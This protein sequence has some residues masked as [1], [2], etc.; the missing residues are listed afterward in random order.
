M[1]WQAAWIWHPPK[2]DMDNFYLHARKL[3]ELPEPPEEPL[4]FVTASSLYKLFVNGR[5]VGRGPNPADPSRYYFDTYEVG[6]YLQAGENV[7]AALCYN[8]G[9][10]PHGILNQNWGRG[11]FLLEIRAPGA[12]GETLLKTD[13]SW[14]VLQSPAREQDAA[15]NCT[16]YGDFKEIYDSQKEPKGWLEADFDD[17]DWHEAEVLGTP[18]VEPWTRLIPREIPFLDGERV[19]PVNAFWESASVTYSWREDNEVYNHW[20]LA[21]DCSRGDEEKPA[22]ALRTHA[23]FAPSIILDFGRD[24]TGYLRVV[25]E[26]SAGGVV[27]LLYGEDLYLTRVD[28]FTLKGGPQV[29]EPYNRRTFRYCKLLFRETPDWV[30]IGEVSL[31]MDTY[32][33]EHK[34]AFRCSDPLLNR[35]WEVG[36]YTMRMS[37]LDHFVDCPWRERTLYGGDMW[38]ENLIAHY[39]FGDPR[40]NAKCLRQMANIQHAGG[41]LPPYGPYR[42]ADGFYPS[43]SAFWALALL[44]H[45][46]FTADA[47]LLEELWPNLEKLLDWAIGEMEEG[48]HLIGRPSKSIKRQKGQEDYDPFQAWTEA[49]KDRH[50]PWDNLPFAVLLRR[51]AELARATGREEEAE[52]YA[53]AAERMGRALTEE[54][55]DPETSLCRARRSGGRP[56]QY[57]TGMLLWADLLS[58]GEASVAVRHL[59]DPE[60]VPVGAPFGGLFVTE[61]LFGS[62]AAAEALRFIRDYWGGMLARGATTYWDNFSLAWSEGVVPGRNTSLCH[63]WAAG[64]TYSLPAH[65]LGV[66]PLEPGF[67]R[68]IVAPQPGDVDWASGAVPTPHGPVEVEWTRNAEQFRLEL[69]VPPGSTAEV[70]V[71]VPGVGRSHL[72]LD[73]EQVEGGRD[74]QRRLVEVGPGEHAVLVRAKAAEL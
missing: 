9:P 2:E 39:A 14:R 49:D 64:P 67:R 10:K 6:D 71:P 50:T 27:D 43:W 73:G 72:W 37:M 54:V 68:I 31:K 26:D 74:G 46:D 57:N 56:G 12:D 70:F 51:A 8:Y 4:L 23:D 63:G 16:L 40:M 44:D 65:V 41:P 55:V 36:R 47:E 5:P 62:G 32:P 58:E 53:A 15:L 28:T 18:P 29:L 59:F 69:T 13:G 35:I 3:F 21:P 61:G 24:V 45:Y 34:G 25:L 66:R 22:R 48:K 20:R 60:V 17:A 38:A 7:V 30:R 33:V 42:G 11:G 19:H 1:Q 52:R